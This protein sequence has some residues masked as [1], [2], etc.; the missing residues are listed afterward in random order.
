MVKKVKTMEVMRRG[1]RGWLHHRLLCFCSSTQNCGTN[2][3]NV[4][5]MATT[6][7]KT[8]KGNPGDKDS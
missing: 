7:L 2:N 1:K 4:N 5:T 6:V 8:K 3:S